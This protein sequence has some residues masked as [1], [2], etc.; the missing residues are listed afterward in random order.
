LLLD[1]DAHV[2]SCVEHDAKEMFL[3]ARQRTLNARAVDEHKRV[4][5]Q[6]RSAR[7][8][9]QANNDEQ[10]KTQS[11]LTRATR[12]SCDVWETLFSATRGDVVRR[13]NHL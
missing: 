5:L 13:Q 7:T 11:Q 12:V 3:T 8:D 9:A 6:S 1:N 10:A 2:L 4:A